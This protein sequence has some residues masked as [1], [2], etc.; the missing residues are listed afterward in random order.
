MKPPCVTYILCAYNHE[1]FV[2]EALLSAFNQD[3]QGKVQYILADDGSKDNTHLRMMEVCARFPSLDILDLSVKTNK[4]LT[5]NLNRGIRAASGEI[6]IFQSCDD[7]AHPNRISK[8]IEHFQSN[9]K[10]QVCF[11]DVRRIDEKGKLLSDFYRR[12]LLENG[13]LVNDPD[14]LNSIFAIGCN[15][16]ARKSLFSTLGL[17]EEKQAA[18]ED[19]QLCLMGKITGGIDF[20]PTSTLDYRVHSMNWSAAG[21]TVTEHK[22]NYSRW[23]FAAKSCFQNALIAKSILNREAVKNACAQDTHQRLSLSAERNL[24]KQEVLHLAYFPQKGD[25]FYRKLIA[26]KLDAKTATHYLASRIFGKYGLRTLLWIKKITETAIKK[27]TKK[28][29]NQPS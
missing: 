20:V 28:A 21:A 6:I 13:V 9:P 1:Q 15:E 4:G 25:K 18:A 8:F 2:E 5:P 27:F 23:Q 29:S 19:F 24:K 17:F 10:S 14:T 26:A 22:F 16:A 3:Y 7:L 11:F 12:D